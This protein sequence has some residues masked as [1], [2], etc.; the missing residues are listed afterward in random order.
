MQR[1]LRMAKQELEKHILW[2]AS[3]KFLF[4]FKLYINVLLNSTES[5]ANFERFTVSEFIWFIFPGVRENSEQAGVIPRSFQ[6]IF[7]HISRSGQNQQYLVRA[8]YL[9]IYQVNLLKILGDFWIIK[10]D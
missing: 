5:A 2:K 6:H 3:V 9:E 1:F 7:E 8:S 10:N 4:S